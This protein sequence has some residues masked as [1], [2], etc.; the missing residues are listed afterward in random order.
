MHDKFEVNKIGNIKHASR[1]QVR[2]QR[3]FYKYVLL[4]IVH[5]LFS[6]SAV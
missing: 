2:R 1:L 6:L 4:E 5:T 3:Y